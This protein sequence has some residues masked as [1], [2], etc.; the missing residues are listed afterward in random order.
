LTAG[1][2]IAERLKV[3]SLPVVTFASGFSASSPKRSDFQDKYCA[4]FCGD[5]KGLRMIV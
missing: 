5:Y 2:L 4:L 1:R 3:V